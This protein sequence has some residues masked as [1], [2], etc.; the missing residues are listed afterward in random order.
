V[1]LVSVAAV[2]A[3]SFPNKP[4]RIV[5][6][7]APGGS[8]DVLAR[9]VGQ[10]LSENMGQ[11]VI[12]DNRPGAGGVVAAKI[13]A[14]AAA[15]GHTLLFV[16]SSHVAIPAVRA[17]LP[18]DTLRDFAAITL[19][20]TACY[21]LVVPATLN[22]KTPAELIALAKARPGQLN[23]GSGGTG[24][25]A[26]FA[27][28]MFRHSAGIDAVH[29]P[30]RGI[31]EALTDLIS[32]RLQFFLSPLASAVSLVRDGKLR[33]LGVTAK[34]R[35]AVY[36]DVPTLAESGLPGFQWDSWSGLLAPAKTPRAIVD[37]LNREITRVLNQPEIQQR[38]LSMGAEASPTTP[39]EFDKLISEQVA[40]TMKLA[41]QA[42]IKP[43]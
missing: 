26:H 10:K 5:V 42:G 7:T 6:S 35:V 34:K 40:L 16:S 19:T 27:A 15:D 8:P 24:S 36:A 23:Y 38:L 3:Q 20:S 32:G 31:P 12:V 2:Q 33:A 29:V 17:N 1:S 39:Q 22:V 9:T 28:E 4:I 25:G 18:Y 37:K 13:V 43:E 21:V 30:Y 41:K 14:D 11:Q